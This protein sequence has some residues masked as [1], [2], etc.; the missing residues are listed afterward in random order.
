MFTEEDQ[1]AGVQAVHIESIRHPNGDVKWT[2]GYWRPEFKEEVEF[3]DR[4]LGVSSVERIYDTKVDEITKKMNIS[5]M[6]IL[7]HKPLSLSMLI[8]PGQISRSKI[9]GSKSIHIAKA[10][11][12]Y[13]QIVFQGGNNL[14]T[15]QY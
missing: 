6:N 9:I 12:T 13:C 1:E 5:L 15:S 4:N 3:G 2:V 7:I 8:S 10:L 11:N 14:C